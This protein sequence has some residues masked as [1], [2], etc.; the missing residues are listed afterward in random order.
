MRAHRGS[1]RRPA[2]GQ[3]RP[4]L[5]RGWHDTLFAVARNEQVEVGTRRLLPYRRRGGSEHVPGELHEVHALIADELDGVIDT[6]LK[7][8]RD[9][10]IEMFHSDEVNEEAALFANWATSCCTTPSYRSATRSR[11]A[12]CPG[13]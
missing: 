13:C 7:L 12:P 4:D 6:M 5:A 10:R 2:G 1:R 8:E 3:G 11:S 9:L